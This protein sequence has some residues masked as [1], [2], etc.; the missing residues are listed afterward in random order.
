MLVGKI[1]HLR[2]GLDDTGL[3]IGHLQRYGSTTQ[4]AAREDIARHRLNARDA[5]AT[6]GDIDHARPAGAHRRQDGIVFD[7]GSKRCQSPAPSPRRSLPLRR[8]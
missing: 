8:S 6:D 2:H 3:V 4:I 5:V 7:A 1:R